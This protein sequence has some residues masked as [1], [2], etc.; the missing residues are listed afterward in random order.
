MVPSSGGITVD[1][2]VT[3]PLLPNKEMGA[4]KIHS[5]CP[6]IAEARSETELSP[7]IHP[8]QTLLHKFVRRILK[9]ELIQWL[10]K[11]LQI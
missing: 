5:D 10:E 7:A 2:L 6:L 1:V 3:P 9:S 8:S 11:A 4:G